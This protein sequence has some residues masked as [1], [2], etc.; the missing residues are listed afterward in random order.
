MDDA[1][2]PPTPPPPPP[3]TLTFDSDNAYNT[4]LR[5]EHGVVTY[6]L[7]TDFGKHPSSR[8]LD[9]AGTRL[10]EWAWRDIRGDVLS[11]RDGPP[12]AARAWLKGDAASKEGAR[13]E[14]DEGNTYC[15]RQGA[16]NRTVEAS[17]PIRL[18]CTYLTASHAPVLSSHLQTG[19]TVARFERSF[20]SFRGPQETHVQVPAQLIFSDVHTVGAR[21]AAIVAFFL[22]ERRRRQEDKSGNR[23]GIGMGSLGM[24]A[25]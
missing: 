12:R 23:R 7:A 11:Y 1:P 4:T 14:D 21:D 9:G 3:L 10:A 15:W 24:T 22:Q 20:R 16:S 6:V 13:F 5:D 2:P 8:V 17:P 19:A 25:A 18:V